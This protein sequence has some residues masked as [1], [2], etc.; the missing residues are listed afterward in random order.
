MTF[1][2]CSITPNFLKKRK[3]TTKFSTMHEQALL[4]MREG[5]IHTHTGFLAVQ[6]FE[7]KRN[8]KWI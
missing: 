5:F 8:E 3:K 2:M 7:K 4:Q 6:T 1:K